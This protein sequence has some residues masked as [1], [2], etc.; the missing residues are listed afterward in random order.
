MAD[1]TAG[2]RDVACLVILRRDIVTNA[3][4]G[5]RSLDGESRTKVVKIAKDI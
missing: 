5:V 4:Y 3:V 2:N 1:T